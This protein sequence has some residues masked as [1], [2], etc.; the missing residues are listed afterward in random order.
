MPGADRPGPGAERLVPGADK[1][2]PDTG[3]T[4]SGDGE[5]QTERLGADGNH[6]RPPIFLEDERACPARPQSAG[7]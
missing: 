2:G 5:K 3:R 6:G 4:A 7:E 1:L